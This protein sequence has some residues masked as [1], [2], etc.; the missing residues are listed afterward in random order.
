MSRSDLPLCWAHEKA[1][2][3][4]L[5]VTTCFMI[6]AVADVGLVLQQAWTRVQSPPL[7]RYTCY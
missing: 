7:S 4:C 3:V 1:G 2:L 6:R 5:Q